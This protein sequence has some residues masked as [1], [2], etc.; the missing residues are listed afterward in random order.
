M[1]V[2][3]V[4]WLLHAKYF[5]TYLNTGFTTDAGFLVDDGDSGHG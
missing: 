3:I 2:P 4:A 1:M 5:R